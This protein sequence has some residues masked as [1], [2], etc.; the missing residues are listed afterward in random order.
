[1]YLWLK[2]F[3]SYYGYTCHSNAY[4]S[5]KDVTLKCG[6]SLLVLKS[7]RKHGVSST[8][9]NLKIYHQNTSTKFVAT[10]KINHYTK[11]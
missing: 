2:I 8:A 11:E 9:A 1:M 7:E 3:D 6:H 10:T 4:A 5:R